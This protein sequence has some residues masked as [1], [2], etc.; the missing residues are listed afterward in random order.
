[1]VSIDLPPEERN[2]YSNRHSA[3]LR[4]QRRKEFEDLAI[5]VSLLR[6]EDTEI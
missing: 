3:R 4:L 6:S 1:M 5:N 2:V